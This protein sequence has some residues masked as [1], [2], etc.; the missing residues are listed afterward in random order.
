MWTGMSCGIMS[1]GGAGSSG[2]S[3]GAS[4]ADTGS[5][6]TCESPLSSDSGSSQRPVISLEASGEPATR[7]A[8]QQREQPMDSRKDNRDQDKNKDKQRGQQQGF[9]PRSS[10]K[11]RGSQGVQGK[12]GNLQRDQG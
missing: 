3:P 8:P 4:C 1:P 9:D 6:Q 11:Q 2:E 7:S 12:Q 10:D 5:C